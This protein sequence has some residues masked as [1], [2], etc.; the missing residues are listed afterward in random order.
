MI[1]RPSEFQALGPTITR[2]FGELEDV[3]GTSVVDTYI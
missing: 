2:Q 3:D 1:L